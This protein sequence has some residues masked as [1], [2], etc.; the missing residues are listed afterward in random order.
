MQLRVY[1]AAGELNQG[2]QK[3]DGGDA[4]R[5]LV[6][7]KTSGG[8]D[9]QRNTGC[10]FKPVHL[11]PKPAFAQHVAMVARE[12]DDGVIAQPTLIQGFKDFANF[13]VYIAA[14][15][16][17][18][19]ACAAN[20]FFTDGFVPEVDHF[21]QALGVRV[22][23]CLGN[24]VAR[25][26]D[27]A[28]LVQVPKLGGD[29]VGVVRM[30]HRDREAK[31]LFGRVANVVVQVLAGFEHDL[32]VKIELVGPNRRTGLEHGRH[33]VVPA[34]AHLKFVPIHGPAVVCWINVTG[35]AF[36]IPMQLVGATKMHFS[37]QRS[38]VPQVA[39]VVGVGG[40]VSGKVGRIV[41]AADLRGQLAADQA[42]PRGR[43]QRAVAIG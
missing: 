26:R 21:E 15:T 39:K 9:H 17:V 3:V 28:V 33:V 6:R 12:H 41:K 24:R 27:V 32:L 16:E 14:G 40:N 37:G 43:A 42:K 11:V 1:G 2:G 31:R 38:A 29:G 34:G 18:G 8:A 19:A 30:R 13:G 7:R 20:G 35:E 10:H 23:R 36:F 22:L 4:L 5:Y 25:H